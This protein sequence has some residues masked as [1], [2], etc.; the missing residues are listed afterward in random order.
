MSARRGRRDDHDDIGKRVERHRDQTERHELQ[1]GVRGGGIEELRNEGKKESR[2]LGIQ[3]L[4]NDAL[5][6]CPRRAGGARL[7]KR[8]K[9][10]LAKSLDAKP[11]PRRAS[12]R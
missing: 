2:R 5:A 6:K 8:R 1:R 12:A 10:C 4:D 7:F 3:R 11:D 9:A